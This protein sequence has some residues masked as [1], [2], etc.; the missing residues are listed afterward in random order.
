MPDDT[1][2]SPEPAV[3]SGQEAAV[4]PPL[5]N[6]RDLH[7]ALRIYVA[8]R[9]RFWTADEKREA[10]GEKPAASERNI[11]AI[12][13]RERGA[14]N[15]VAVPETLQF[16]RAVGKWRDDVPGGRRRSFGSRID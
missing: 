3:P 15:R 7:R 5:P 8:G 6:T 14:G 10:A 12:A 13:D 11:T 1:R 2:T 16:H 4:T 9:S